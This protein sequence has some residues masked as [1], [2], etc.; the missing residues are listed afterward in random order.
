M[1]GSRVTA[2]SR[3]SHSTT[4]GVT[5][6]RAR[7]EGTIVCRMRVLIT[8]ASC[9]RWV[10]RRPQSGNGAC[11]SL[12]DGVLPAPRKV[13]AMHPLLFM[14]IARQRSAELAANHRHAH[15]RHRA[16]AHE[17]Q[18]ARVIASLVAIGRIGRGGERR[19]NES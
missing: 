2:S 9:E 7:D 11:Y 6:A 4:V 16:E 18:R 3:R 19:L 5:K 8:R 14:L 15:H 17:R 12:V 10:A 1:N 13:A